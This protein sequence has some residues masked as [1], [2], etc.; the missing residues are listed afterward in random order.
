MTDRSAWPRTS[1]IC[2]TEENFNCCVEFLK[3]I[4]LFSIRTWRRRSGS[5]STL[6]LLKRRSGVSVNVSVVYSEYLCV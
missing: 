4:S 5:K 3:A 1:F 6:P 2:K